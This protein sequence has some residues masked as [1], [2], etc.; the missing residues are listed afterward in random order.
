[1]NI[2]HLQVNQLATGSDI[3]IID[4]KHHWELN[5]EEEINMEFLFGEIKPSNNS[6]LINKS[7]DSLETYGIL[8]DGNK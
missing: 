5:N 7:I 2:K 6:M 1:M 8:I 4:N 3:I